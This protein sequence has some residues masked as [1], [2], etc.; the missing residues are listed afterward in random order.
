MAIYHG[1]KAM[2]VLATN[3]NQMK[4]IRMSEIEYYNRP[5]R[6][7]LLAKKIKTKPLVFDRVSI[8]DLNDVVD[9]IQENKF[10]SLEVK[11][12]PL[13]DKTATVSS[14]LKED[15][16][17]LVPLQRALKKEK[18]TVFVVET[19]S[20]GDIQMSFDIDDLIAGDGM[21]F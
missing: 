3:K 19:E 9:Y 17:L 16:Y 6:G 21:D 11:N 20:G 12:I 5:A 10:A 2:L 18:S 15:E 7:E 8:S 1:D 14:V 4:R 13:M